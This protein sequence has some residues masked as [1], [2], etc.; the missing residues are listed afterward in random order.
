MS[1]KAKSADNVSIEELIC[2][3]NGSKYEVT[4][5]A[6]KWARHIKKLEEYKDQPMADIIEVAIRD[7][8]SGKVSSNEV[9]KAVTKDL[10]VETALLNKREEGRAREKREEDRASKGVKEKSDT[11]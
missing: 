9:F 3:Y 7:I 1:P 6:M 10:A 4:M 2:D 8:L 11:E 5:L